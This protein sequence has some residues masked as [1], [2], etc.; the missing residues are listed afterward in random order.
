MFEIIG[1]IESIIFKNEENEY[2]VAKLKDEK[3]EL[4][5]IVGTIPFVNEGQ[6]VKVTGEWNVHPNFGKQLKV[7]SCEEIIPKTLT[8]IEKYLASGII[9]GIGPVTAKKIVS[10]FKEET[11]DVLDND[12]DRLA[13]IEGIGKK[14]IKLIY[15]SYSR[16]RECRNIMIFLQPYGMTANQCVKVYNKYG[17]S[18]ID[19]IK[20]NPYKLVEDIV[21]VGFKTADKIALN[22][23]IEKNSPY[24]IKSGIKYLVNEFCLLGNTYMPMGEL[25]EKGEKVLCVDKEEIEKAIFE[26]TMAGNIK[27]E[28][29]DEQECVFTIPYYYSELSVTKKILSLTMSSYDKVHIDVEK[30]IK[31]FENENNIK[32]AVSQKEAICGA[33]ENGMEII[34]GG[35]GTGKTTIINCII[36]IFE[37]SGLSVGMAAPTGRAAKRMTEA[38][39]RE[40]KTIHRLLEIGYNDDDNMQFLKS[41]EDPLEFDVIIV[42]EASMID[43]LLMNNLLKAVSLGTRVIIVGDVDQLPSVGPGNVLRDLIESKC[44]NVV[45]LKEIFRQGKES[46]IVTNAHKIN[47]SEMPILNKK[48]NDFYFLRCEDREKILNTTLELIHKRLPKFNEAWDNMKD[49]QILSPTRKGVL[50]VDN[51]NKEL[52]NILNP[53]SKAKR[54]KEFRDTIF[55]VGDKVMQIKNNYSLK[56]DKIDTKEEG[57]GVYNGDI[58]YISK[59]D[60]DEN[61]IVVFEDD[62]I[63]KYENTFLDE[64]TLA[65]AITIHKSQG[66][67]FPVVII[68]IFMGPPMLMNKN[69]LYTGI[70]RAKKLAVLVGSQKALKFMVTNDRSFERYSALKW[71]ITNIIE[72]F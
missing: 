34:T 33:F 26:V 24:R 42:D 56:W 32:F 13:E 70:T 67:E 61:V 14:K 8:G 16:Q 62:R 63:V 55:R 71:R 45:R 20:Q 66:S 31:N 10:H 65:Y 28:N 50:G 21:G 3:D 15:E 59:I 68:P 1:I 6:N 46:M 52:Q 35:P 44:V 5:T 2:T 7:N 40:A 39:G 11:L 37:E 23:G 54:E 30:E 9:S 41:E 72:D 48:D 64:L 27:V 18:G 49:I 51:L 38:T 19:I 58:G 22:L 4:V 36:R 12:I 53:K 17:I 60:D 43:I 69:L 47:N 57:I 25:M 29:I